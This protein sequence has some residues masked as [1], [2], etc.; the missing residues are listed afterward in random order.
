[1][2]RSL[3]DTTVAKFG[4]RRFHEYD[5][6]HAHFVSLFSA[7]KLGGFRVSATH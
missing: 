5:A 4:E 3:R 2:Y 1:M 7:G 6:A